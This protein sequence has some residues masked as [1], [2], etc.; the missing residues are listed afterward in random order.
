MKFIIV[1]KLGLEKRLFFSKKKKKNLIKILTSLFLKVE[2]SFRVIR[3]LCNRLKQRASG[4]KIPEVTDQ[5]P[6]RSF[7]N[8]FEHFD[9]F[10]FFFGDIVDF[11][12]KNFFKTVRFPT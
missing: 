1:V 10:N 12:Q 5:T 4:A 6:R 3:A 11:Y 9:I 2:K 8:S 7:E